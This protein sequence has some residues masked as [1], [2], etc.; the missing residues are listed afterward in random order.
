MKNYL[1]LCLVLLLLYL[2]LD[3]LE[4]D[5]DPYKILGVTRSASQADIKRAYKKMARNWHPDKNNDPTAQEMFIKINEANE[6]LSDEEKKRN[7][8]MLGTTSQPGNGRPQGKPFYDPHSGFSFF[9]NGMPFQNSWS[10][11]GQINYRSYYKAILPASH[12]RPYLIEIISDW[13]FACAQIEEIWEEASNSVKK[14]GVGIGIININRSPRLADALGVGRVPSIIGVING[15][16]MF[17]TEMVTVQGLKDFVLGL[18]PHGLIEKVTARNLDFFLTTSISNKPSVV[19]FSP[20]PRPSLLYHLVAFGNHKRQSFGF[21][22]LTDSSSE[23][24]RKRFRVNLKEPTV[25]IFKEE[26]A[27][28]DV[29]VKASEL[30]HGKLREVVESHKYLHLPRLFSRSVFDELCPE[31]RF[32]SHRRLCVVLFT[33]QGQHKKEKL[34][35]RLLATDNKF[36]SERRVKFLYIYEGVQRD[37]VEEFKDGVKEDSCAENKTAS[38]VL[39]LWNKG[40]RKVRYDWLPGGWC[41]NESE[42]PLTKTRLSVMLEDLLSGEGKLRYTS[43][44]PRIYNEHAPGLLSMLFSWCSDAYYYVKSSLYRRETISLF[45][46]LCGVGVIL[47]FSVLLPSANEPIDRVYKASSKK[48][49]RP[50]ESESVLGLLRLDHSTEKTLIRDA[51]RGQ[52]TFTLLVDATTTQEVVKLPLIQAY[53]DLVYPYS[54]NPNFKFTWLSIPDNLA[55]CAEILD[56][57]KFGEVTPGIVLA[58]NGYKK[59]LSVFKPSDLSEGAFFKRQGGNLMGFDDTDSDTDPNEDGMT[60]YERKR[61]KVL[62]LSIR[63]QLVH[64]LERFCDGMTDRKRIV[65]WPKFTN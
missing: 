9:F 31:E 27:V 46:L 53:A 55:W 7:F 33:K 32:R 54:R 13:C 59:Y 19:L 43:S 28:P 44:I 57:D 30:K 37:F 36:L 11:P 26:V 14:V 12:E 58:L 24:L 22:S 18:F 47:V 4:P 40:Q 15:R 29:V 48:N 3:A 61:Q 1:M 35:L 17:Y 52:I 16:V 64:W 50:L 65:E 25:L 6:I 5:E 10:K 56:V 51:P 8:D 21:V 34:A 42:G 49:Q 2:C 60:E 20:K 62:S 38:K 39:V 63:T 41:V 45:S 23:P